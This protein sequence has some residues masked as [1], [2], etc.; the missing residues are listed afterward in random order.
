[1][2]I[3]K[4]ALILGFGLILLGCSGQD[5][6]REHNATEDDLDR[7]RRACMAFSEQVVFDKAGRIGVLADDERVDKCLVDGG[8]RRAARYSN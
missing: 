4:L 3:T 5:W 2:H 6:V 7:E 1:M 8:W